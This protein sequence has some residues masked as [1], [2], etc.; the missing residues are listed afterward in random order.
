MRK[1]AIAILAVIGLVLVAAACTPVATIGGAGPAPQPTIP[2]ATA[3]KPLF[4]HYYLWWDGAHWLSKV[5]PHYPTT[6]LHLSLPAT[7]GSNGCTATTS[8]VGDTL[9]DVPAA[10]AGMYSQDDPATFVRHVQ[11][12]S[13]A[14]ID[15]FVVSWS[16]TGLASQTSAS[17]AF[18]RRLAM[19]A[20]AVAAH[21]AA[22]GARRF[23][24]MLGYE[25][26]DNSRGPRATTAVANDLAYFARAYSA[27][28]VFHVSA[29]GAKPV[30]ML[31]DSRKF[32]LAALHSIVD[33]LHSKITFIGDEH[34]V[35]EWNR[36]VAAMFDGDGWYWSAENPYTNPGAFAQLR[37]LST[38]LHFEHKLWFS[39][40]AAGYN[41]SNFGLGGSCVPRNGTQTLRDL[42]A[43][44]ATS[45]P[46][47]WM[48]I[49]WNE[50]LENTYVEPSLR[51][52]TA[53]LNAIRQLFP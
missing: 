19:L 24:L 1:S 13:S 53:D 39:P 49:S 28:P 20:S 14:G 22:A 10:P 40:L 37:A 26:L 16:G 18:S 4:V 52:G 51:Y 31:L 17:A 45:N 12:A 8:Y 36:G 5:G 7:L 48:L 42:Y 34:G 41:K 27:N 6:S 25:G 47:G 46:D 44:N 29:Y 43:G 32:S 50:F 3:R 21:N 30:V 9:L 38:T 23:S 15:G 35:T 11:E 33:P 2:H